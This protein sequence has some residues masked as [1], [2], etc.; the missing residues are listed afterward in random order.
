LLDS[1]VERATKQASR[2]ADEKSSEVKRG[3]AGIVPPLLLTGFSGCRGCEYL[4]V[5]AE[6]T[7]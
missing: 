6:R 2:Q 5:K 7:D 1:S 3:E 4:K